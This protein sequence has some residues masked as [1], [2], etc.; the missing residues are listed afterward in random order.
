MMLNLAATNCHKSAFFV[1]E[2][3]TSTFNFQRLVYFDFI[4]TLRRR[5]QVSSLVKSMVSWLNVELRKCLYNFSCEIMAD[6][7]KYH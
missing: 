4:N 1:G 5:A 3:S 6:T 7:G 2:V